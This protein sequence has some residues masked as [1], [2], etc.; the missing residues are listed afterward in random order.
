VALRRKVFFR[1]VG[2]T[3]AGIAILGFALRLVLKVT[4]GNSLETYRSGKLVQWS[5]GAALTALVVLVGAVL[6]ALAI[7]GISWLRTRR[8]IH[9]LAQ[10]HAKP[11]P[12][13][14]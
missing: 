7:R 11:S 3:L 9:R 10:A 13:Q 12:N 4:S 6:V 1:A 14:G 5:Y 2:L 8:E